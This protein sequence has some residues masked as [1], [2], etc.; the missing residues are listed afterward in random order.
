MYYIYIYIL[1]ITSLLNIT[2]YNDTSIKGVHNIILLFCF[3]C[4][5]HFI[6]TTPNKRVY[7]YMYYVNVFIY[8]YIL[9]RTTFY[10]LIYYLVLI[11]KDVAYKLENKV[12]AYYIMCSACTSIINYAVIIT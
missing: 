3:W 12:V 2:Y 8:I 11:Y 9:N 6:R 5:T 4:C 1:D 7:I 10:Y